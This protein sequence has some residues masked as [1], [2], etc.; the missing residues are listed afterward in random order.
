LCH[1]ALAFE[2]FEGFQVH[3]FL[4]QGYFLT[5]N[6]NLFGSS[7]RG[8]SLDFTE[9]GVNASWAP[10]PTA[11]SGSGVVAARRGGGRG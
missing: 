4:S 5:T 9:I 7:E 2:V 1:P 6:N 11:V 3:G 8:G 10:R